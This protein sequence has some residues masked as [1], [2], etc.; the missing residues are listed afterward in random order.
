MMEYTEH[1]WTRKIQRNFSDD[2]VD[3]IL[4]NGRTAY[5][6]GG[7]VKVFFGKKESCEL[8]TELKKTI[9]LI[10]R[11][12]GGTLILSENKALTIYKRP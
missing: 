6:P 4:S 10:E 9:K 2:I 3:I 5:A 12:R 1:A 8:I 7:A 11:A